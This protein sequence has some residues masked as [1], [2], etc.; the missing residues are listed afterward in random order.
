MPEQ[1]MLAGELELLLWEPG[2][3]D[4]PIARMGAHR[5]LERPADWFRA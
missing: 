5:F 2:M 3:S 4:P 1:T